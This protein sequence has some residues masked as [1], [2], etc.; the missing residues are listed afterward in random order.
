MGTHNAAFEL[1]NDITIGT[2]T[3]ESLETIVDGLP[4]IL[5]TDNTVEYTPDSDY[6][7]AT[8]KY[9]D[10]NTGLNEGVVTLKETTTPTPVADYG[11]L[12]T[13]TDNRLY[14]QDGAGEEN[15]LAHTD[16]GFVHVELM[17]GADDDAKL[18]AA[19]ATKRAI[20]LPLGNL[21]LLVPFNPGSTNAN[22]GTL[23]PDYPARTRSLKGRSGGTIQGH[24]HTE[25]DSTSGSDNRGPNSIFSWERTA[26]A[27]TG[28]VTAGTDDSATILI[29]SDSGKSWATDELIGYIVEN[30]SDYTCGEIVSNTSNTLTVDWLYGPYNSESAPRDTELF[31]AGDVYVINVPVIDYRSSECS[32]RDFTIDGNDKAYQ[33]LCLQ[34]IC[35]GLG[36]G[37]LH[38]QDCEIH[39]C[40]VAIQAGSRGMGNCDVSLFEKITT[41]GCETFFRSNNWMSI[42][43]TFEKC[44]AYG[45]TTMFDIYRG[46]NYKIKDCSSAETEGTTNTLIRLSH[47]YGSTNNVNAIYVDGLKVDNQNTDYILL[48]MSDLT[49]SDGDPS[50]SGTYRIYFRNIFFGYDA[51][52]ATTAKKNVI[53]KGVGSYCRLENVHNLQNEVLQYTDSGS[54]NP[55]FW[56]NNCVLQTDNSQ[57]MDLFNLA[58]CSGSCEIVAYDNVNLLGHRIPD[59]R[60]T[61]VAS[62]GFLSFDSAT[63]A[64]LESVTDP[65]NTNPAA[66]VVG[67]GVYN[68][69]TGIMYFADGTAA[70]D[71]W[72]TADGAATHSPV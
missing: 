14:F 20:M 43:H 16:L 7:P 26:I 63:T 72:S 69:T 25:Y 38:L 6:E 53:L 42:D 4:K 34:K 9:V 30:Q 32:Y 39:N 17:D 54:P 27:N 46:G 50:G 59:F 64:R 47:A 45:C 10:D 37:K 29:D 65:I 3:D 2:A 35:T 40:D 66:K 52:G 61:I 67:K 60:G 56:I 71:T 1:A 13:K 62:V 55:V 44:K 36:V 15:E 8:K 33:G 68:T 22:T 48:D 23:A 12:Y 70:A 31:H 21:D 57:I 24:G 58:D 5:T 11:K 19:D 41:R 51:Y 18:V 28:T 49:K